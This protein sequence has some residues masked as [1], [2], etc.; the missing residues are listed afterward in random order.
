MVRL[1]VAIA[2]I[3]ALGFAF[4]ANAYATATY[5]VSAVSPARGRLDV[6]TVRTDGAVAQRTWENG[7]WTNWVSL[8]G[9]ARS[10][11]RAVTWQNGRIDVFVR[12]TDNA[13]YQKAW[14]PGSGWTGWVNL[15]GN[16]ASEISA[17]PLG[18]GRLDIFGRDAQGRVSYRTW[19]SGGGWSSWIQLP[20]ATD[21]GLGP[22]WWEFGGPRL[23]VFGVNPGNLALLQGV[24][25][26]P[27]SAWSW[28]VADGSPLGSEVHATSPEPNR[29]DLVVRGNDGQ[30][31]KKE[32]VNNQWSTWYPLGGVGVSGPQGVWWN[33][34]VTRR[35]DVFV[36][37]DNSEVHSRTWLDSTSSWQGWAQIGSP[38]FADVDGD[39]ENLFPSQSY[40]LYGNA[41][42]DAGVQGG[43]VD[44]ANGESDGSL[45]AT[46][47]IEEQGSPGTRT[48]TA[49]GSGCVS[50]GWRRHTKKSLLGFVQYRMRL[51]VNFCFSGTEVTSTNVWITWEDLSSTSYLHGVIQK[52]DRWQ[53]L[54]G[55]P[56]GARMVYRQ[57]RV[58]NC[59]IR[60]GCI[61]STYP[62]I[63]ATLKGDGT[64]TR[65]S[66]S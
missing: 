31:Y 33:D 63:R 25:A 21:A 40:G 39:D 10:A 15:G 9:V 37:G 17:A 53:T 26:A 59:V 61:A 2:S 50:N 46:S 41:A 55:D 4:V 51:N 56:H 52:T 48:L 30:I 23:D 14:I 28:S 49:Q 34:G 5:G 60:Y 38:S 58:D 54:F 65:S 35:Y 6:F 42:G 44:L 24:H 57:G 3:V 16:F 8:S 11:P 29:L 27:Y 47:T 22:V 36:L 66:G 45:L 7:S 20:Q 43:V 13:A 62:W 32:Y 19:T 18:D 64:W 1:F 12:G